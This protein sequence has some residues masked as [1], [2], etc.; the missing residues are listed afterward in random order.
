[1]D[2]TSSS[3]FLNGLI[4]S[5]RQHAEGNGLMG[6]SGSESGREKLGSEASNMARYGFEKPDAGRLNGDKSLGA[7]L[8]QRLRRHY[9]LPE[10]P[11]HEQFALLLG[12]IREKF[13][14]QP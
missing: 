3:L 1:M 4:S 7:Q 14:Q 2:Q 11:D 13:D 6:S 9:S 5:R 12:K 10:E 8:G